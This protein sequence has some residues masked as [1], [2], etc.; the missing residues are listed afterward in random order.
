MRFPVPIQTLSLLPIIELRPGTVHFH[1][2]GESGEGDFQP[3]RKSGQIC[4]GSV[5]RIDVGAAPQRDDSPVGI[6]RLFKVMLFE[7]SKMRFSIFSKYLS[8]LPLL[9]LLDFLIE[10]DKLPA[11]LPCQ[12]TPYGRLA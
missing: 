8:N 7:G 6:R 10:I 1:T 5:L 2:V 3:Y 9:T 11:E 12:G 4:K